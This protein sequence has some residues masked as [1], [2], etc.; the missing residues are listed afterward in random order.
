MGP[1]PVLIVPLGG[2]SCNLLKLRAQVFE[3]L[4]KFR[5]FL[6]V[7]TLHFLLFFGTRIYRVVRLYP[8]SSLCA[9]EARGLVRWVRSG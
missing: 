6:G 8:F 9:I 1:P 7:T 5:T 3:L 2:P 4:R